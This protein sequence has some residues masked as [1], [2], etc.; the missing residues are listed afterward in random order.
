MST[1]PNRFPCLYTSGVEFHKRTRLIHAPYFEPRSATQNWLTGGKTGTDE[2]G[3]TPSYAGRRVKSKRL[4]P[5]QLS[6]AARVE[7]SWPGNLLTRDPNYT[8]PDLRKWQ[9]SEP[10]LE[11]DGQPSEPRSWIIRR[12][13]QGWN[14]K[15]KSTKRARTSDDGFLDEG[16]M[17]PI[18]IEASSQEGSVGPGGD[19][20]D[21]K[22]DDDDD[23]G[24]GDADGDK[25]DGD[26]DDGGRKSSD[27]GEGGSG[28][29]SG[30]G[31]RGS[32][33]DSRGSGGS[34]SG[35]DK[36]EEDEEDD[37]ERKGSGESAGEKRLSSDGRASGSSGRKASGSSGRKASGG[38]GGKASG[39]GR[40]SA[41]DD[42]PRESAGDYD[43]GDDAEGD[44][45]DGEG[46]GDGDDGE[47]DGDGDEGD[48]GGERKSSDDK[49]ASDGSGRR[50]SG[51][52]SGA[53]KGTDLGIDRD[54]FGLDMD[55]GGD[56][57]KDGDGDDDDDGGES[58][59]V[60]FTDKR[61][62]A[63]KE[64]PAEAP[65]KSWWRNPWRS[66]TGAIQTP[67]KWAAPTDSEA[68][69]GDASSEGSQTSTS[70]P[71]SVF[72]DADSSKRSTKV[73]FSDVIDRYADDAASILSSIAQR[74]STA[75][76]RPSFKPD[77]EDGYPS[78]RSSMARPRPSLARTG[79]QWTESIN[80][81]EEEGATARRSMAG[82]R[83]V[84]ERRSVADRRKSSV[85]RDVTRGSVAE[86]QHQYQLHDEKRKQYQTERPQQRLQQQQ[87][88][89]RKF[90]GVGNDQPSE[91]SIETYLKNDDRM[92]AAF[93]AM[94]EA[95]RK[96]HQQIQNKKKQEQQ[97]RFSRPSMARRGENVNDN[98]SSD[99]NFNSSNRNNVTTFNYKEALRSSRYSKF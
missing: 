23:D 66:Q 1:N 29:G 98:F 85:G 28:S 76:G 65:R 94:P 12:R 31:G 64:A 82:R 47:G 77:E 24:K 25:D 73:G 21:D 95:A 92:S 96:K 3:K 69:S 54:L 6:T 43:G 38:S 56:G 86:R 42:G 13:I 33:D 91:A 99:S 97:Q 81:D 32:K 14:A 61:G 62:S 4:A 89:G 35:G 75:A 26:D 83:S 74:R 60:T 53:D 59:A 84:V 45:D 37:G 80:D 68:K 39:S 18:L 9:S 70:K 41:G 78:E 71:S 50:K 34:G 58:R 63:E 7:T 22:G 79:S 44:G 27:T 40:G 15:K 8:R 57:I 55:D 16:P 20:D 19:D 30:D 49:R 72:S 2:L 5:P 51:S 36:A 52:G 11:A 67:I 10:R 88:R 46:D 87:R 90:D 48:D 17:V 93:A